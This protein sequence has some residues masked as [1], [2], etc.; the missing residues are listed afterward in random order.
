MLTDFVDLIELADITGEGQVA[1]RNLLQYT[2]FDQ[3]NQRYHLSCGAS[4]WLQEEDYFQ[5]EAAHE[6]VVLLIV[7]ADDFVQ[8]GRHR[9]AHA[10]NAWR[11]E[12]RV[13]DKPI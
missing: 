4:N 5:Q 3:C 8:F 2:S 9:P 6:R 11:H 10:G 12:R 7:R 13:Q 1:T